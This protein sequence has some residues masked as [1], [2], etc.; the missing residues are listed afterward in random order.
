[1]RN[2]MEEIKEMVIQSNLPGIIGAVLVLFIGWLIALWISGMVAATAVSCCQ[3]RKQLPGGEEDSDSESAGKMA[4][5]I[6]YWIVMILVLLGCM[7][8]LELEYAAIPLREFLTVLAKYLPNIAG[9]L[10]LIVIARITA[11]I[12]RAG[13]RKFMVR[14][15]PAEGEDK[16]WDL[17]QVKTVE[18][19]VQGAGF[20]V[21]LFFLPAILNALEIY[22][23][24]APL[25]AMFA[26]ALVYLPRAVAAFAIL[27]VGLWAAKIIRRGVDAGLTAVKIDDALSFFGFNKSEGNKW[28]K[29]CAYTVWVLTVIPVVIAALTALDIAPLTQSI[30][31]FLNMLLAGAGNI[32]G[33][34]L[35]LLATLFAARISEKAVKRLSA[36]AGVDEFW[37]KI[38]VGQDK[39]P[40]FTLS[41]ATGKCA[42]IAVWIL[43][44]IAA[45]DMLDFEQL[46]KVLRS[47]ALFGGN[48]VISVVVLFI[49]VA[50]AQ[51]VSRILGDKIGKG[52]NCAVK[53]AVIAFTLALALSN[54]NIG[55]AIVETAFAMILG[56]LCVAGALAFGLGGREFAANVLKNLHQDK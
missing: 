18:L 1:M 35:V 38:G 14:K 3:W 15:L 2:F 23:I 7:S 53:V 26:V 29:L 4:S 24:T 43:G 42:L 28:A 46:S 55:Q 36:A 10:L 9:A 49:G 48:L 31:G 54:L 27:F 37:K 17:E 8:L 20:I 33:A 44:I 12:V 5:K 41:E 45:C 21:Y 6:T 22:G 16:K 25:Q 47:F 40:G 32:I 19:S 39:L 11:G 52:L 30:S 51:F 50:L 34:I 56:A 13:V